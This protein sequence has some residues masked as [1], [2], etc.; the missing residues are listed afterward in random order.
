MPHETCYMPNPLGILSGL[1]HLCA[2]SGKK[3]SMK[4]EAALQEEA[5][6]PAAP[7]TGIAATAAEVAA[8]AH[9]QRIE[10]DR[11]DVTAMNNKVGLH[12]V[13]GTLT[14]ASAP[15]TQPRVGPASQ[16][17]TCRKLSPP[18]CWPAMFLVRKCSMTCAR[19]AYVV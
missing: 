15:Y 9:I 13:A 1:R 2:F 10:F 19:C 8:A 4:Q 7:L 14:T 6:Y 16:C 11:A 18:C 5:A 12:Y 17:G 3:A